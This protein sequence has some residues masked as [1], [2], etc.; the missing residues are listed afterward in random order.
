VSVVPEIEHQLRGAAERVAR[1]PIRRALASVRRWRGRLLARPLLVGLLVVSSATGVALAARAL[2]EVGS[3]APREYPNLG[4]RILPTGTR[5]LSL[6]IADPAGGPPWGVRLIFTTA[7]HRADG[8]RGDAAHWGCVQIGR[9]LDGELGV[10]GQDGA[11]HDDGRF[12]AL[13]IQPES[14]GSLNR[15]AELVGLTGASNIETASAYQGLHG[16]VTE[17][18]RRQQALALPSI[19]RQLAVAQAEGDAQGIRSA[20]E[21]L[22][23][24]RRI[25]PNVNA[26]PTCPTASL[27]HIYFGI[28]GPDARSVTV[29]GPGVKETIAVSPGNDGAYLIVQRRSHLQSVLSAL[30]SENF[31]LDALALHET[32]HY[33]DGRSCQQESAPECLAPLGSVRVGHH[34]QPATAPPLAPAPETALSRRA[35][36]DPST[37]NPVTVTPRRGGP[38]TTFTLS[39]RSLLNGGGYSYR[40]LS[41]GPQR[42]QRAA[43]LATGG[44]GV[45]ISGVPLVRGQTIT[46]ALVPTARALCPGS[47]RIY[48]S[49]SDPER[50]Q[51]QNFPFATVRFTVSR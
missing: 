24:Y 51:L 17:T 10:L 30:R 37:P 43:E 31:A 9:V 34:R 35:E 50:G 29:S 33:I 6:R 4:E 42:C 46:K 21:G 28:A 25:A 40:I 3:P 45:A 19:E 26:E 47:Y 48:I 12:H 13:P 36:R 15:S 14:C 5:L 49:Y 22:A 27:R 41:D 39:F 38:H 2:V 23:S 8:T 16:C 20:L 32:I 11:F 7:D 18:T 44:D 1:S